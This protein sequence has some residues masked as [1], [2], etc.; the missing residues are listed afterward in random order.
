MAPGHAVHVIE[1]DMKYGLIHLLA[2]VMLSWGVSATAQTTLATGNDLLKHVQAMKRVDDGRSQSSEDI[3]S[4]M[5]L[6]GFA[7]GAAGALHVAGSICLPPG[8]NAGQYAHV[9]AQ[10][11]ESRPALL[12]LSAWVLSFAALRHA[13][14]CGK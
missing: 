12:H 1:I 14:P 13:F 10:Y 8:S 7:N 9:I 11:L 4:A 2:C 3:A 6:I 5:W